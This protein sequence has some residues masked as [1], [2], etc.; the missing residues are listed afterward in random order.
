MA[1][2]GRAG[3]KKAGRAGR[4]PRLS[5]SDLRRIESGLKRGPETLGYQTSLW[6]ACRVA[7]LIERE[8]EVKYHP[9]HVGRIRGRLGWSCQRPTGRALARDEA[10]IRRGKKQHWPRLKKSPQTGPNHRLRGRER[11]ERAAPSLSHVGSERTDAG[12]AI[13]LQHTC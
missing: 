13:P 1:E 8:C 2:S 11:T 9:A 10:A 5:P 7:H 12:A 6:T 4:K 3:L